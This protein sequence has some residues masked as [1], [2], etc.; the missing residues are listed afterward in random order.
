MSISTPPLYLHETYDTYEIYTLK[1]VSIVS[2]VSQIYTGDELTLMDE[3]PLKQAG[4]QALIRAGKPGAEHRSCTP[5]RAFCIMRES[6]EMQG[7]GAA[8][9]P[10]PCPSLEW[11]GS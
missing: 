3:T 11:P 7:R 1:R 2:K 10:V 6:K 8:R 5:G 9:W 4:R